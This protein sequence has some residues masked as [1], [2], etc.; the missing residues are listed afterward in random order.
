MSDRTE[1]DNGWYD[2][3]LIRS[4]DDEGNNVWFVWD[5]NSN[6]KEF[7]KGR[8]QIDD[9][10]HKGTTRSIE[11][12]LTDAAWPSTQKALRALGWSG[13]NLLD[14]DDEDLS[15]PVRGLIEARYFTGKNGD[16]IR[17]EEVKAIGAGGGKIKTRNAMNQDER[18]QFS[19]RLM[20][21]VSNPAPS[22]IHGGHQNDKPNPDDD[23]PF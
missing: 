17:W 1:L 12:Y 16:E 8:F 10:E 4:E 19:A 18:R 11:M 20:A 2:M 9:E 13:G 23:L 5:R 6:G 15:T 3:H 14:L 7:L 21:S 22:G